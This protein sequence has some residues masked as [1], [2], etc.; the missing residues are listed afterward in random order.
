M[1]KVEFIY[2]NKT[3]IIHCNSNE[4]LKDICLKFAAKVN[5]DNIDFTC[6]LYDGQTINLQSTLYETITET[7]KESNTI[8]ILACPMNDGSDKNELIIKSKSI[9]CPECGENIRFTIEDYL[10]NLY[11]CKNG[12]KINYILIDEFEKEQI[13][14]ISKIICGK[15][16]ERNKGD[17]FENKFYICCTCG[18][19]ICPLC[20]DKHD[21]KHNIINYEDKNFI[22]NKHNEAFIMYCYNCKVNICL[23]CQNMHKNHKT[24]F[25]GEINPD[26]HK[27]KNELKELR[28]E[29]DIFNN[30]TNDIIKQLKKVMDNLEIYYK[31][32]EDII[33][34]YINKNRNYEL[35]QNLN[36]LSNNNSIR[37]DL[38]I[39]NNDKNI[40]NKIKKI[41]E[42][43]N[44]M[45]NNEI[46]IIYN[47]NQ[48][49][50]ISIF[51]S[52]FVKNNKNNCTIIFED[53]EYKLKEEFE[54]N[55]NYNKET[56]KI[57]LRGINNVTNMS[58]LF[59]ICQSLSY[60]PDL[61]KWNTKNITNMSFVFAGCKYLESLPDISIW[62]TS[63]VTNMSG[64]FCGCESLKMLPDISKWDTSNVNFMGGIYLEFD[65]LKNTQDYDKESLVGGIFSYC[66]SLENLPDISK[67]NINN[68]T[69]I[70]GLFYQCK[71]LLSLPDISKWN[72]DNVKYISA[73]FG[74][75]KLL[76][77]L[78][79]ISNWNTNNVNNMSGLFTN[80]SSLEYLPDISNW[81]T[82]NVTNMSYM[83]ENCSELN[84]LPDISKWNINNLRIKNNM[85]YGC[86]NDLN[87]PSTFTN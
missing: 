56:L 79:D 21:K 83:F 22:C 41:L 29:I 17:T 67:W 12:H 34:N 70:S 66:S 2:Q 78:P 3:T 48:E 13:I 51:G 85:F 5:L 37:K 30:K 47:T 69:N 4:K 75:C 11:E 32:S 9:I 39:I 72:I 64:M 42:I 38:N 65:N 43:Y 52:E 53:K 10:I 77:N 81:N 63:N 76:K 80:C 71:S 46:N 15:C 1:S 49:K 7:D 19:N 33:E 59:S 50:K 23:S 82:I 24:I 73:M 40:S 35:L 26:I 6:F 58:S 44:K 54:L 84:S 18:I 25:F 87:I 86:K 16:K 20:K 45:I 68:V 74:G 31:L 8:K 57:K 55:D 62:N 27:I 28:K 61:Q 60:L 14:D 36:E